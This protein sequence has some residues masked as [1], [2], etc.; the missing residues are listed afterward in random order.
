MQATDCAPFREP[1]LRGSPHTTAEEDVLACQQPCG[2]SR[3]KDRSLGCLGDLPAPAQPGSASPTPVSTTT[4]A[5]APP[6]TPAASPNREYGPPTGQSALAI[7]FALR[8]SHSLPLKAN[9]RLWVKAQSLRM[10]VYR[11]YARAQTPR[12]K[13]A[14]CNRTCASFLRDAIGPAVSDPQANIVPRVAGTL[15]HTA[16][17]SLVKRR[18]NT[19]NTVT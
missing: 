6:C 16:Q 1:R 5:T 15:I 14:R 17:P 13:T 9:S 18:H 3:T 8:P 2:P 10:N 7:F 11:E 4:Q 12:G 19:H